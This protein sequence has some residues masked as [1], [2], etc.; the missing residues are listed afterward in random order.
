MLTFPKCYAAGSLLIGVPNLTPHRDSGRKF[1]LSAC[2]R[3]KETETQR[4]QETY[5]LTGRG[6]IRT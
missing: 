5:P 2:F 3:H 1:L 6:A 4:G